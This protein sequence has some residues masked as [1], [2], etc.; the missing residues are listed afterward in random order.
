ME[1]HLFPTS[2]SPKKRL[3]SLDVLRG[4][5]LFLL[6][7]FQPLFMYWAQA[8][9]ANSFIGTVFQ[10]CFTHVEWEG[11]HL[12][13]QIMPLFLFMAG[14]S[15]PYAFSKYR[16]QPILSQKGILL[17][18]LKRV[19]LLWIFGAINQGNLLDLDISKLYLYTDTLQAIAM[20]YF[21]SVLFFLYLPSRL[22]LPAF[23]SLP[24]IYTLGM[25][26]TGG[27]V[28]GENLAEQIDRAI[29]GRFLYGAS[30]SESG[31]VQ[32]ADWYH[33]SWIYS[34]LNFT[35][36]VMSGVLTGKLLKSK[37]SDKKKI[38]I[39]GIAGFLFIG[40]AIGLSHI[41]P[42][43]KRLWTSSMMFLSSGISILLMLIFYYYIDIR[44]KGRSLKWLKIYGMNS[45]LSYMLYNSLN[46]ASLRAYWLHGFKIYLG[47][48]YGIFF[49]FAHVSIVFLILYYCYKAKIYLK[50]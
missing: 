38:Y 28:P 18:I 16:K 36:T 33:I 31:T 23:L 50:V 3:E 45:I 8:E 14:T 46:T 30:V 15:I 40:T 1:N 27:Y 20:G 47:D 41:E 7:A 11:F 19:L 12:W 26:I 37:V 25:L 6:V 29:L 32:F 42:I 13:D 35:A 39:L 10:K 21:F 4:F 44:K 49:E 2:N 9:G 17:R 34:T 22:L 43:I 5:D 48:Y 24:F